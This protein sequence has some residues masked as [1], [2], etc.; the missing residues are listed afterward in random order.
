M[1]R[2]SAFFLMPDRDTRCTG[3]IQEGEVIAAMDARMGLYWA[4]FRCSKGI[5]ASRWGTRMSSRPVIGNP[6]LGPSA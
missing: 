1:G 5:P 6:F 3:Q 2:E 4:R